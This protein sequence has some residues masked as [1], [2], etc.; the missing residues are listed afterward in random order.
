[1]YNTYVPNKTISVPDD[2]VP[3][4]N[5]LH[6]PFSRWVTEQLRSHAAQSTLSFADQL[7]ADAALAAPDGLSRADAAAV[8]ERMDRSAPW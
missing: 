4:I 2:V 3:I 6:V 8:G 5:S 7:M 1:M